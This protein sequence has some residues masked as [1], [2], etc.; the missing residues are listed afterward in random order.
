MFRCRPLTPTVRP[1]PPTPAVGTRKVTQGRLVQDHVPS[2][3]TV[4]VWE[5]SLVVRSLDP[6]LINND[7]SLVPVHREYRG[8]VGPVRLFLY[9]LGPSPGTE[10]CPDL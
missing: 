7:F 6:T 5:E 3:P 9:S 2:C 8:V 10:T 4:T 1:L